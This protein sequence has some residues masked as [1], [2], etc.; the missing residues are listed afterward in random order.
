MAKLYIF[1]CDK[2]DF[3]DMIIFD[4]EISAKT[5]LE[6][7]KLNNTEEFNN[8]NFRLEIFQKNTLNQYVPTY[9]FIK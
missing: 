7:Q 2:C 4:N 3:E 8:H 6:Q 9:N 1:L 5:Y